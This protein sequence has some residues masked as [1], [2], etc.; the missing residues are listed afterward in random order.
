MNV[1]LSPELERMVA[2]KVESGRYGSADGVI[3][4][5]LELLRAKECS[6][7]QK[8]PAV[9]GG[10]AEVFRRIANEIPEEEWEKVPTDLARNLDH[11]L[12]GSPKS[13]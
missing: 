13:E 4:E 1:T 10:L 6:V 2:E 9:V 3:R 5:G 12:Y 8:P 7:E 11:Y